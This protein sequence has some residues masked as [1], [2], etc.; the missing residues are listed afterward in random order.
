[1]TN[2]LRQSSRR[3]FKRLKNLRAF[4]IKIWSSFYSVFEYIGYLPVQVTNRYIMR[5]NTCSTWVDV[6]NLRILQKTDVYQSSANWGYRSC[7]LM[8][9]SVHWL[10]NEV[11]KLLIPNTGQLDPKNPLESRV[12]REGAGFS[13]EPEVSW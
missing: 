8:S 11:E 12:R 13:L 3:P 2:T 6:L 10:E 1:M 5:A 7:G 4:F 9:C